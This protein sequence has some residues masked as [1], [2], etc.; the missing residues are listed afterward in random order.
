M[1]AGVYVFDCHVMDVAVIGTAGAVKVNLWH[2][3]PLKQIGRD[4]ALADHPSA[5]V[6]RGKW[7]TRVVTRLRAPQ[8]VE[9][10]DFVLATSSTTAARFASAFGVRPDQIITAGYPRTDPLLSDG[11]APRHCLPEEEQLLEEFRSHSRERRRILLYMPTFRDWNNN[12]GR[13]IPVDW[14]ALDATLEACGGVLYCKLHPNDQA[15][16]PDHSGLSRIRMV[17]SA[18]DPYAILAQTDALITDYSSVFFD[19][20][21]LDRPIVFYPYD[22]NEYQQLSRSLYDPYDQVTPGPKAYTPV[23]LDRLVAQLLSEYGGLR[24]RWRMERERVRLL[25]HE[26]AGGSSERLLTCLLDRLDMR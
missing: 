19:Y 3:V 14:A 1:R 18:V 12:A 2:G 25:A 4:I 5:R 10:Y 23:E 17:P 6:H 21:V 8:L 26:Y 7:L 13:I 11:G 15:R 9:R 24:S 22:L 16:L 20:L